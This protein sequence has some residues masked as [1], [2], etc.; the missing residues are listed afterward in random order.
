APPAG[1]ADADLDAPTLTY[2]WR[3][4]GSVVRTTAGTTSTTDSLDLSQ[5]GNG[6]SGD[7]ITMTVTPNDGTVDGAAA[8]DT[9]SVG[10]NHLPVAT[11][12]LAPASPAT[13]ATVTATATK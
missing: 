3:V 9:A 7:T 8:T 12:S 4:N 11:V 1:A 2:V 6:D 13:A 10:A 5:A